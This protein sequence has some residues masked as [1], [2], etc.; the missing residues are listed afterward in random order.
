LLANPRSGELRPLRETLRMDLPEFSEAMFAWKAFL[1]YRWRAR[2]VAPLLQ[3]TL[4]SISTIRSGWYG[5]D[6]VSFVARAKHLLQQ[7]ITSAWRDVSQSL[8]GYDGAFASLNADG[9]PQGLRSFLTRDSRLFVEL[10]DLIGRLAQ[11]ASFWDNRFGDQP[12][13]VLPPDDVR[14]GL[15]DLLQVLS[16]DLRAQPRPRLRPAEEAPL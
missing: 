7:T 12:I 9:D 15:R 4:R 1:Y 14:D 6:E 13:A 2:V 11:V 16:I 8:K 10:G 5:R 3:V